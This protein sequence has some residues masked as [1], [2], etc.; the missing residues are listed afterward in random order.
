M[1]TDAD[2]EKGQEIMMHIRQTR[3][4]SGLG[5]GLGSMSIP[6]DIS[7]QDHIVR[8]IVPRT[9]YDLGALAHSF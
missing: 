2:I 8:L 1:H 5:C 3:T 7:I 4:L 6:L 9:L